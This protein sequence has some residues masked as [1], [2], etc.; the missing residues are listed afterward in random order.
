MGSR[1]K[2]LATGYGLI[3]AMLSL[4]L[5][6]GLFLFRTM[7]QKKLG[8]FSEHQ[9][10]L[11]TAY[12]ASLQMYQLA[13]E[14]FYANAINNND[15]LQLL[16]TGSTSQ[17]SK[18][19]LA[20]GRLYRRIFPAY[21]AIKAD[22]PLQLQF[23]LPDGTSF[24]RFHKPDR[25]GDP[26]LEF[27]ESIRLANSEKRPVHGF[28]TGKVRSGFRYV[29][30]LIYQN[31]HLGS[32]AVSVTAKGIRDALAQL[33]PNREYAFLL[34]RT[35]TKPHI[36]PE[37]QWLYSPAVIHP[38]YLLEDANAILPESPPQLSAGASA[39]N[40][41][42]RKNKRVQTALSQGQ[43]LTTHATV[44]G[45]KHIV[46]ML[47]I[48]D[49]R[50]Q[51]AGYLVSY[52]QDPASAAF[53]YEFVVYLTTML[54]VLAVITFL[55]LRIRRWT[56]ALS[57]EKHNL[58]AMNN[59][60]AE[61]VYV[62]DEEGVIE[63]INPAACKILGFSE[64]ELIGKIA[65][66]LFHCHSDNAFISK[67]DC[68]FFLTVSQ[69]QHYQSEESFRHRSG[70][71]LTVELAS[72]PIWVED[73]F[74]GTVTAFHDITARKVTEER[75]KQ[76]EETARKLSTAVEQSPTAI[77]ITDLEGIIEYANPQF[78]QM[79]GYRENEVIG[80]SS[81]LLKSGYMPHG[82]YKDL[83]RIISAGQTWKGE[84]LN[85]RKNGELYWELDAISP[86]RDSFNCI[87][88]YI[89]T[90]VD[91]SDR[92]RMEETLRE[93]EKIQRTLMERLPIPLV[94]IDAA[95]RIIE[96]VN[97]AAAQ[98]IGSAEEQIIGN[99]CHNFLCP[100][101]EDSCPILDQNQTVDSSEKLLIQH[102]GVQIPI[103]K[104]VRKVTIK[105]KEKL[106]ECLVDIRDRLEAEESLR[107]A[108]RQWKEATAKAEHLAEAADA[109]N[110]AKSTFLASMSHEIRTPLNAILGYSQLLQKDPDLQ[111]A[112][113]EQIQTINRSGDHLLELINDILEI[114]R[115][116]A[117]HVAIHP[118]PL[119]FRQM[120][121]DLASMFKLSC[122]QKSLQ[123]EMTLEQEL[124]QY[125]KAD[126]A[127]IRQVLINLLSNA[128]KFTEQGHISLQAKGSTTDQ[129]NWVITIDISDSGRGIDPSEQDKLFEA[130]EQTSSGKTSGMGSGLGL[131]ISRA[132]A[133]QLGGELRLE[134]S[135]AGSGSRFRFT[136]T[137]Q[138]CAGDELQLAPSNN[139]CHI[140]T[141]APQYLPIRALVVD[142]DTNS[143]N[144]LCQ[145]LSE[146]G[147]SVEAV[148]CGEE[149]IEHVLT[150][151]I[152][153]VLMDVQ[154]TGMDG[155]Q[156]TRRL[157]SLPNHS[158]TKVMIVT[159]GG[160]IN[161]DLPRQT[162]AAGANDFIT[163]P[164]KTT[165]LYTKIKTLCNIEYLYRPKM[166]N[167]LPSG[168]HPPT[169][170]AVRDLPEHLIAA[171]KQAVEHGD[172]IR[173]SELLEELE[174]SND[175]LR[176]YL[177]T[178]A[179]R[180]EYEKL[181]DFLEGCRT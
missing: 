109:A 146:I 35:L 153:L 34:S 105:G 167:R 17:G 53:F 86:I 4:S 77:I 141:I 60:L 158:E 118:A 177:S 82:F 163:K 2:R 113:R 50:G 173:F 23:Y 25:Y 108:N 144:M 54:L 96:S 172:M 12:R 81:R 161:D 71:I 63:R 78:L 128:V 136:F 1:L 36:F 157:R 18:Q 30:P 57:T 181:L 14:N 83:W 72:R 143:R 139:L 160:L 11:D 58:Q 131:S 135:S 32:I 87:T 112:Q 52:A 3:A 49:I 110:M 174:T 121:A 88:H 162:I 127:K 98:L 106:I 41:R 80:Q 111:P 169:S 5:G 22:I 73:Q 117:G 19:D 26:L 175:A 159:A 51:V 42:L 134:E 126:R 93:N 7:E 116:E 79:T 46:S 147:F 6:L 92:K 120:M 44:D 67:D 130:F 59:A 156:T 101:Q 165:E 133:E 179:D 89:A 90:K 45:S 151:Q 125:L 10:T 142:D 29:Y 38:D 132:Y 56:D 148:A 69:G 104:T 178:L 137:A 180:Y 16:E 91:I 40:H 164:F 66:D 70:S 102:D 24:L 27:Q 64:Q 76:S 145:T 48:Q 115:I 31:R 39:I 114:S 13:I 123:F 43:P 47:P 75:L 122:Q 119:D 61:G 155:Y 97:P 107:I 84:M 8:H 140:S 37:Q 28:E 21:Q 166:K 124:P 95:S 129:T 150:S 176:D 168:D 99:R 103:L 138:E 20:R 170:E 33:D 94:I 55:I 62:T 149:A 68:P 9:T 85:R 65:H 74:H 15:I 100:A 154:M 152:D 171:L